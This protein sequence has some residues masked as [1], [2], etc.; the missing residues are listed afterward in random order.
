MIKRAWTEWRSGYM[1]RLI[2]ESFFAQGPLYAVA[3]VAMIAV[4]VTTAGSA[5]MMEYII[6]AMT[7]PE[8]RDWA[9][10]IALSV[11]ALFL[12]KAVASYIQA[13][14]LARAG[15]R[16]VAMQ[17]DRVYRKLLRHGV[18]FFAQNESSDLLTRTT[19]GAQSA[20]TLIDVLVTG[21]V[22][23]ALTLIGLVVVMVYQQPVLSIMFFVVGPVALLGVRHLLKGVRSI[24]QQEFKSLAEII[25]VLQETTT[26]IKVIKVFFT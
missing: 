2:G 13:I 11:V 21:F 20:R 14:Y 9:V 22:R 23:D 15:N 4:A 10:A 6:D 26:G 7:S 25:R 8:M 18:T 3:I 1:G 5:F 19:L 24:M 16:I 17:Q 12:A